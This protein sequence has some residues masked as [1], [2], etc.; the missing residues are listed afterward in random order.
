MKF[1]KY[2]AIVLAVL[3]ALV[4]ASWLLRNTIIERISNPLLAR[5]GLTVTGVSLDALAIRDASIGRLEFSHRSGA[6]IV[7]EDL[8]MPLRVS[9]DGFRSY[10]MANVSVELP[11]PDEA[12]PPA[13]AF[14]LQQLLLL[15]SLVPETR[16]TIGAVGIAPYPDIA[17]VRWELTG[18]AQ[19]LA[20]RIGTVLAHASILRVGDTA[21]QAQ[22]V[23]SDSAGPA[24]EQSLAIEIE[25]AGTSFR[26]AGLGQV[27][28]PFWA[29]L[30]G[31]F[32]ELPFDILAGSAT[33]RFDTVLPDDPGQA[34]DLYADLRPLTPV[35][36]ARPG[37]AS[38][39]LLGADVF[40]VSLALP[41]MTWS[42]RQPHATLALASAGLPDLQVTL[43]N[44]FCRSTATCAGDV[45]VAGDDASLP[46]GRA[47][48][49]TLMA[50]L[51]L[52]ASGGGA[53]VTLLPNASL[54]LEEFAGTSVSARGIEA[55]LPAG[56]SAALDAGGWRFLADTIDLTLAELRGPGDLA[57]SGPLFLDQVDIG[58]RANGVTG[59]VGVHAPASTLIRGDQHLTLPA[60]SGGISRQGSEV[61]AVLTTDGLASDAQIEV[62]HNFDHDAGRFSLREARI[63]FGARALSTWLSPWPFDWD[64]A[65]GNLAATLDADWRRQDG[66]WQASAAGTVGLERLAGAF[67]DI[68]FVGLSTVLQPRLDDAGILRFE[69][70]DL[71]ISLLEIGFP[72]EQVS[73]R[74]QLQPRD[75]SIDFERLEMRVF[76]GRVAADPFSFGTGRERNTVHLKAEAI[77][78]RRVLALQDFETIEVSGKIGAELPVTIER[79]SITVSGGSLF[80]EL[81]GG[82]IRYLPGRA[83]DDADVSGLGIATR[84]L[85]NFEYDS[86]TSDLDYTAGGDLKLRM[87][88]SGRNPDMQDNRPVVLN[89]GVENNVPQMLRSLQAARAVEE[90]LERRLAQP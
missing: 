78:L 16:V 51:E 11:A 21:H 39:T 85:S 19:Q 5:Y 28:L 69:P 34:F 62:A 33:L 52:D 48:R 54:F 37:A 26:L 2:C 29:R 44:L 74:F 8:S 38:A 61:A 55:V 46:T 24:G 82:V 14:A 17:D 47:G 4:V 31:G 50:A 6:R 20:L 30:S 58:E 49:I 13:P 56:A 73:A 41:S 7:V 35:A 43:T 27:E 57:W 80:G 71:D 25:R 89:L 53:E 66:Q 59:Q 77:D 84:A 60:F 90:V 9:P 42:L 10:R 81:P 22:V 67:G 36:V 40:E 3:A 75:D 63:N 87:R 23:F 64:L 15:P 65:A 86:L 68:A 72:V 12:N 83:T 45:R 79:N 88:L 1:T 18:D 76:G 32:R 70:A